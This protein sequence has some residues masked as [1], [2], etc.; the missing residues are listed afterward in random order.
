VL[1]RVISFKLLD[2]IVNG[3]LS[4]SLSLSLPVFFYALFY[5]R[6]IADASRRKLDTEGVPYVRL[7]EFSVS[8][9]LDIN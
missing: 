7:S 8:L 5:H 9:S 6:H 3:V 2:G 4:L 1:R